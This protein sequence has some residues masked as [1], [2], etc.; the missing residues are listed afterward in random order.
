MR[1]KSILLLQRNVV[2]SKGIKDNGELIEIAYICVNFFQK[3]VETLIQLT[4]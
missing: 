1:A 4:K 2:D 3:F